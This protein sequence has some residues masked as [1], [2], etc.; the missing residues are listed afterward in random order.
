MKCERARDW[1]SNLI[2]GSIQPAERVVLEAH[3]ATCPECAAVVED[4]RRLW[5]GLDAMPA[6]EPP[7]AL[8]ASIWQ[9][10]DAAAQPA[11][12]R[13]FTS[14]RR[15]PLWAR[16]TVWAAAAVAIV[17]LAT[18]TIPGQFRT[19]GWTSWIPGMHRPAASGQQASPAGSARLI[20]SG[21]TSGA[22]S[23]VVNLHTIGKGVSADVILIGPTGEI[24]RRCIEPQG[25]T[26]EV[27]FALNTGAP[28]PRGV[29]VE[30]RGPDGAGGTLNLPIGP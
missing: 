13:R 28:Q 20:P 21:A 6:L 29:R 14:I 17:A 24:A 7:P 4:L 3:L 11:S 15:P 27:T 18:V 12:V 19:A 9:R 25:D 22:A 30:W 2:D 16:A 10:I 5:A 23:V 1:F 26:M 8:R